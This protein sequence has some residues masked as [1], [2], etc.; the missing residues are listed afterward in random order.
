M[1]KEY[2]WEGKETMG[3]LDNQVP[4]SPA[5]VAA[6]AGDC[7]R[8]T[9]AK[10][11]AVVI[12]SRSTESSSK[13][14]TRCA[15]KGHRASGLACGCGRTRPKVEALAGSCNQNLRQTRHLVNNAGLS[16]TLRARRSRSARSISFNYPD[17]RPGHLLWL[18][19]RLCI[20]SA[21]A[22]RAN[23]SISWGS[24]QPRAR[25]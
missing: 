7:N 13:Q 18:N 16:A 6:W 9:H 25:A 21:Q 11:L 23:S 10:A 17:Q 22:R 1:L 5:A 24:G 2:R 20:F 12:A 8:L 15:Q 4:S 19:R 3:T 14:Q